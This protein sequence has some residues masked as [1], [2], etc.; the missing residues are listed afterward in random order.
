[1]YTYTMPGE[2]ESSS[3]HAA[4]YMR[5]ST[6]HGSIEDEGTLRAQQ[7]KCVAYIEEHGWSFDPK[8]DV[9]WEIASGYKR[10]AKRDQFKLLL[11]RAT[12]GV[13][14]VVVS[15]RFDRASRDWI[16]WGKI[17]D[18]LPE[19]FSWHSADERKNT[20][21]DKMMVGI[22]ASI[23]GEEI[24]TNKARVLNS[25][26]QRR[27]EGHFLGSNRP[28]GWKIVKKENRRTLELDPTEAPMLVE[29]IDKILAG[30]S[31]RAACSYLTEQGVETTYPNKV[32]RNGKPPPPR[33]K[34]NPATL[35]RLL[36]SPVLIGY[37][38]RKLAK[39]VVKHTIDNPREIFEPLISLE[40][41]NQL[42]SRLERQ[43]EV[44]SDPVRTSLLA[45]IVE[46]GECGYSLTTGGPSSGGH[47]AVY[48][49]KSR[50]DRGPEWCP[51]CS[52]S[53]QHLDTHISMLSLYLLIR[54]QPEPG[55][56]PVREE[57]ARL[58]LQAENLMAHAH[59]FDT[60]MLQRTFKKNINDISKREKELARWEP[61]PAPLTPPQ[62]LL[63]AIDLTQL[64]EVG[65]DMSRAGEL[66]V[67]GVWSSYGAA[68]RRELIASVIEKVVIARGD[69]AATARLPNNERGR[70]DHRIKVR[71]AH[72]PTALVPYFDALGLAMA[73]V[74]M[75]FSRDP[76]VKATE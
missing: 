19:S 60:A 6:S 47:S 22:F 71:L 69:R 9:Y 67:F 72:E 24:A 54:P 58:Q 21:D 18:S 39:G 52:I 50:Y 12:E 4:I 3:I 62:E 66:H 20:T 14:Q 32:S 28:F 1:M 15:F 59:E 46:C 13:Y 64:Q 45:G 56:N 43:S 36:R 25:K 29:V 35:L 11:G 7:A 73:E 10:D 48:R 8:T 23:A 55:P 61:A 2:P 44:R 49:C 68:Q 17:L 63:G 37:E 31:V 76:T 40:K 65:A 27:E 41:W 57:L 5:R 75:R 74:W 42:Q 53:R 16:Q 70:I 51:G 34:W 33:T 30:D 26:K 38:S